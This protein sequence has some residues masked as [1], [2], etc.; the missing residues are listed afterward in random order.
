MTLRFLIA[1]TLI[2]SAVTGCGA[3]PAQT[4]LLSWAFADGRSCPDAGVQTIAIVR[5]GAT[6]P[7][8]SPRCTDGFSP[9][10]YTL[11]DVPASGTA[12]HLTALSKEGSSLYRGDA[13]FD[14]LPP[15]ASVILYADL[16]R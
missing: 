9:N 4:L 1:S 15:A 16:T 13:T 2:A 6:R 10:S 11:V 12:I 8:E 5:G 3:G 7:S 14:P